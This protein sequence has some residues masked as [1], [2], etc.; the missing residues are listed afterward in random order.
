[1]TNC[2]KMPERCQASI[3]F[4]SRAYPP[5]NA[6]GV[7]RA[8]KF[9][10]SFQFRGF[11]VRVFTIADDGDDRH[12]VITY[13]NS[14]KTESVTRVDYFRCGQSSKKTL[15]DYIKPILIPLC[16]LLDYLLSDSGWTWSLQLRKELYKS[17]NNFGLPD[18][19]IASGSPFF[20]FLVVSKFANKNKI[21]YILDYRD[22]WSNNPHSTSFLKKCFNILPRIIENYVNASAYSIVTVSRHC[23]EAIPSKKDIDV[24]YNYPDQTYVKHIKSI[25]ED[26]QLKEKDDIFK[27][28][29]TGT[30]YQGRDL[31]LI[32]KALQS[33][34]DAY[35]RRIKFH[36]CGN[37]GVL[38]ERSFRRN[39]VKDLFVCHGKL[40]KKDALQVVHNADL[41][42]SLI[43]NEKIS[44][45]SGVRGIMSTKIFDYLILDKQVLNI[46]PKDNELTFWLDKYKFRNVFTISGQDVAG[47]ATFLMLRINM[48][49]VDYASISTFSYPS[50]LC[51]EDSFEVFYKNRI[52]PLVQP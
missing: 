1:M 25:S 35:R 43:H 7:E 45:N 11:A 3:W 8:L 40:P 36:Y 41:C 31:E 6:V 13:S 51:W 32:A 2:K 48:R 30:L 4:V 49:D 23:A 15:I 16:W 10:R 34:P 33:L 14:S 28:V 12:R 52:E 5:I 47:I 18:I 44:P 38:A 39:H 21:P 22:L 37:S 27:I 19:I 46:S 50:E 24:I 42:V 29:Y 20:S 26:S 9:V 17:A